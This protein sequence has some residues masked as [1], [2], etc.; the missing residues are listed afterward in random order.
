MLINAFS[1]GITAISSNIAMMDDFDTDLVYGYDFNNRDTHRMSLTS[2]IQKVYK[3]FSAG[4]LKYKGIR[5]Q[6]IMETEYTWTEIKKDL[7]DA[8]K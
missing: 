6:E 8:V 7:F 5:L 3:D 4:E 2:L 1:N